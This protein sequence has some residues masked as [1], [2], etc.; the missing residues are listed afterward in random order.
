ME[1]A[2]K[3]PVD[4]AFLD[5]QMS[6]MNGLQM[7]ARLKK[8]KPDI[9][10]IFVTAYSE[11][12]VDAFAMHA[13][14]YLLK[15]AE[16]EDVERELTFLYGEGKTKRR[17]QIKTF[18]G[19]DLYVDEQ[20]VRFDRTKAKELLAYLVD[21]RGSSVT[22]GE[23]CAVL[24]EDSGNT[25]SGRSYFR[26]VFHELTKALK[27]AGA[28]EILRKEWNSYAVVPETFDCDFY[29]FLEGDPVVVNQIKANT[30]WAVFEPNDEVLWVRVQR[31]ISV[32]LTNLW[33]GGSLAGSSTD[34]AFF[35]NIGRNTMSQDDIDN[36]RLICVIG[37][38]PVKP[39]EFVIFRI[40][41]KTN[42]ASE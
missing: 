22:T 35:V 21:R 11:Y 13:T 20:P 26:T 14:G 5:I 40:T 31:T 29:R 8:R 25:A 15:P 37:V 17:I 36:G 27:R 7:A 34:E 18:G 12:A 23:A 2:E 38:A 24:F 1:A 33:R 39:A 42:E 19:F 41:Q 28:E 9:H 30:S 6:G 32:F 10:I 4:V 3:Q 16:R